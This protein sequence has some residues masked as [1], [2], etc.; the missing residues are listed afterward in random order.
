M[1]KI[2][3]S[4]AG[5]WK[6]IK[7]DWF[8]IFSWLLIP[9]IVALVCSVASNTDWVEAALLVVAFLLVAPFIVHVNLIVLWHWKA[10]Y[11]GRHSKL[12]GALIILE[13]PGWSRMIYFFRHVLPDRR[14][15]GRYFRPIVADESDQ[16]VSG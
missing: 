4:D 16:L 9:G 13:Q 6:E 10:R 15:R 14:N 12:W 2:L 5:F 1:E 3:N 8:E 7:Y 11:R